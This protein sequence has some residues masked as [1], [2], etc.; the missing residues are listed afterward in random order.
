MIK[1]IDEAEF[2]QDLFP[3]VDKEAADSPW[4]VLKFGGTSVS[5][6]DNWRTIAGLLRNR[7][8]AGLKPV[9]VHS[10]LKSVSNRLD[11]ILRLA[12][13]GDPAEQLAAIRDQH[14]ELAA[15][16][17]LDSAALVGESL[18]E[19]GQ[20]IAGIRLV[21]EVS[22]R[23]RVRVLALGEIMA[24]RLGAE[25][26]TQQGLRVQWVDAREHL[27][28][29]SR[30][31]QQRAQDYLSATC[32]F[33]P[34]EAMEAAFAAGAGIVLT[35]GFIAQNVHGET[36]LLGRGGSD[37]SG[38]YFAARLR[39][40]RLEI[41]TDVPGMFT[42]DPRK[43]P[44][45]RL[46]IALHYDEAQELASAGSTVLHP[47][48]LSP[49]RRSGIPLHIRCT[50]APHISGTV[51]S[52]VTEEIESQ[53]KGICSRDG[54]LLI[55]MD[56]V[57]MWHEVGFLARAF[58]IFS[59]HHV[60]V[61]LVSTSETNVTVSI[62]TEGGVLA[63]QLIH[64]LVSDLEALC[65]VRVIPDCSAISLVGRKIRT[66]LARLAPALEVFEEEKI[67][68]MSQAANDL[69]LS[70]VVDR[71]QGERL[72]RKLHSSIIRKTGGSAAF[73]Q[74]W[75][76]LFTSAKIPGN[77]IAPWWMCKREQ[78][79]ELAG[80]QLNA[81]IY[82]RDSVKEAARDLL[83]LKNVGRILYA[84]KAN[85]NIELLQTLE[86]A[87]VDF[88][89]VSPGEV[90]WLLTA[91][92]K[93]NLGRILFTPNFAPRSEYEWAL[94]KGLQV[95]LDNLYPL[96]AWPELFKGQKLFIRLDPGQGRGHHEHVKTAGVHSKFGV[97]LFEV[98]E[99]IRL[100]KATGATVIG[101][102]AHSGSGVQDPDSWH[103]VAGI[104][105]EVAKRFPS[106]VTIDLGGGLGIPEKPGDKDFD[107]A[108]LDDA[109]G[110]I[111]QIYP[112][113]E[114]WLEP[115]RYLVA[116][117]GVL[118]THVTQVKGKGDM[119][120]V[121]VGTGMNSLIRPALYGAYHEIVN[122]SRA[123]EVATET[124][125]VVGPICETGDRLG[126]DRLLPP[127]SENDVILIANTGAYGYVMRSNY[128][129]RADAVEIVI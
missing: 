13:D 67:H 63:D 18:L 57:G 94:Q 22:V 103:T 40:R 58:A 23:V 99:L 124:V 36:V 97:P 69:N 39:A 64:E 114:L 120:Y 16:L 83:N 122:L 24:T 89:C 95:T 111:R 28:S 123:H 66:I 98:D 45:A 5:T 84:V 55:S 53:V 46:L 52:S 59:E 81:Y 91:V 31:G 4:V 32:D 62:D 118:L 87:K 119:R 68:L 37:T 117:A 79:L 128:N 125:T 107:L 19:L 41:W 43:V 129:R 90:E 102:H 29:N 20:L 34:D 49:L 71:S 33:A 61:G 75:E 54:L 14:E 2:E 26:L 121:G 30:P 88:E 72:V 127:C 17:G 108:R 105:A 85:D 78:L 112:Q 93:L 77:G 65:R 106:V 7:L 12:V 104:L 25:F 113:Y 3:I 109:L 11:A 76:E 116:R 21:R 27:T 6:V 15:A 51:V 101:I 73:G 35:Q 110:E 100:T 86:A 115:G 44:S 38:A 96:E 56:T 42:A 8:D 92:P 74:S 47:R 1:K 48:C 50:T 82:D 9:V 10:A 126:S 60:S 80:R 70:F